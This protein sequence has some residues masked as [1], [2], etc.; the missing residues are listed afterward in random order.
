MTYFH[1]KYYAN[2]L[3]LKNPNT[4]LE[5]FWISLINAKIDLNPHQVDGALFFFKNPLSD[6]VILAD[7]VWLW[8]TIEAWLVICQLWSEYKRKILLIVPASLRKQWSAELEE[9]FFI[10]SIIMDNE[11]Y[12]NEHPKRIL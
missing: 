6:G 4:S 2:Y 3:T 5:R 11:S 1:S 9:K 10:P 7:E 12:K 8:K